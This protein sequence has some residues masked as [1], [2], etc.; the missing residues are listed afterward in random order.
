LGII[1]GD[2]FYFSGDVGDFHYRLWKSD[3]TENG[4]QLMTEVSPA[5]YFTPFNGNNYL[6]GDDRTRKFER[7]SMQTASS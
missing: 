6:V 2:Y 5:G 4:T 1:T 3:G 7:P